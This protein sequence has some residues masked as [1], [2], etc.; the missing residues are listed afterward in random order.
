LINNEKNKE[1]DTRNNKKLMDFE[2][3]NNI[4]WIL[5]TKVLLNLSLFF[6]LEIIFF[7]MLIKKEKL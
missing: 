6:S 1:S 5:Q 4:L 7:W 3:Y 2:Y